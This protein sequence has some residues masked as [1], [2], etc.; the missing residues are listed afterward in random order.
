MINTQINQE[1]TI[2]SREASAP[3]PHIGYLVQQWGLGVAGWAATRLFVAPTLLF[4]CQPTFCAVTVVELQIFPPPLPIPP[5]Q[6]AELLSDFCTL[7]L[8]FAG[9]IVICDTPLI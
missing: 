3:T 9:Q 6:V 8:I 1:E 4:L 7:C 5:Y 2:K